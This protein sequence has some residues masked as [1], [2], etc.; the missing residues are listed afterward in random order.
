MSEIPEA[1]PTV[2]QMH[3]TF[4]TTSISRAGAGVAEVVG[5]L[6]H[7]LNTYPEVTVEIAAIRDQYSTIVAVPDVGARL[8]PAYGPRAFSFAPS[9]AKLLKKSSPDIVHT[10]GIWQFPSIAVYRWGVSSGRPYVVSPHGMLDTWALRNASWKKRIAA[11]CYEQRHLSSAACLHALN[12]AERMAIRAYGLTNPVAVIPNGVTLPRLER[13]IADRDD[14]KAL[15]Y[16]GRLHPKKGLIPLLNAWST[17]ETVIRDEWQLIIAGWD[18]RGHENEVLA[19]ARQLGLDYSVQFVGPKYGDD[20]ARYMRSA[21][22]FVLPSLSEGLPMSILEAWSYGLPVVMSRYCNL[23]IGFSR[24]A[25][26]LVDPSSA[27]IVAGLRQLLAMSDSDRRL[28]GQMGRALVEDR[29]TWQ[30]VSAQMVDLYQW[31]LGGGS[32]PSCVDMRS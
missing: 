14:R 30:C 5:R 6:R 11:M 21:A 7:Y 19:V 26:I 32:P 1:V 20:K 27:S 23:D 3:V 9:F 25:A 28:M 24:G 12:E 2:A 31:V 29:F 4:A 17:L 18:D 13:R 16:L 8:C 22:A 15:L 10:H